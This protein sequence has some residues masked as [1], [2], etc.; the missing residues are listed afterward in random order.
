M[1]VD[2]GARL[3]HYVSDEIALWHHLERSEAQDHILEDE[4]KPADHIKWPAE[5]EAFFRDKGIPYPPLFEQRYSSDEIAALR[6]LPPRERDFVYFYEAIREKPEAPHEE[7]LDVSQNVDR[8]PF[9][10]DCTPCITPGAHFWL[11]RRFRLVKPNERLMLQGRCEFSC[12][13]FVE[14]KFDVVCCVV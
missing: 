6:C 7:A 13:V 8:V 12:S 9:A 2:T 10:Q 14:M 4:E 3:E 5:H 1:F 11:R